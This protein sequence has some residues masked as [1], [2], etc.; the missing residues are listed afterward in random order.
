MRSGASMDILAKVIL[1]DPRHDSL[2]FYQ[3]AAQQHLVATVKRNQ[4]AGLILHQR[5][6]GVFNATSPLPEQ[7]R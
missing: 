2:Y 6:S 1:D 3:D 7:R 4:I 5:K